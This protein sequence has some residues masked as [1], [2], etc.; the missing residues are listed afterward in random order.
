[1]WMNNRCGLVNEQNPCRCP[2]KTKGFVERGYVNPQSLK[3]TSDVLT[4]IGELSEQQVD[5][6]L[7]ERD[8]IAHN[9][10]QQHPFK[11]T[12]VSSEKILELILQNDR[13]SGGFKL[14]R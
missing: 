9:I 7:I 12:E 2:K 8:K 4:K 6:L 11:K 14:E 3:W 1:M 10:F 5:E 13:F